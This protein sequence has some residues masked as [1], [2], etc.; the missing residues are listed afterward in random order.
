AVNH[1]PVAANDSGTMAEDGGTLTLAVLAN[2]SDADGDALTIASVTQAA[3][4]SVA[5][6]GNGTASY[7][8]FA[9]FNGSDTFAYTVVDG[10]GGLSTAVVSVTVTAVNDAPVAA[11][12]AYTINED[13]ALTVAAPGVL[14]N[15]SDVDGDTPT[16][17]GFTQAAHGAVTLTSAGALTYTPAANYNGSD[18][19]NYT[20]S[21]GHGSSATGAVT[22]TVNAVND[23]PVAFSESYTIPKDTLVPVAFQASDA[24]GDALTDRLVAAPANGSVNFNLDGTLTFLPSSGFVGTA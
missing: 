15:D 11:A 13:T 16:V 5:I 9:N 18:S 7:T 10:H 23:A 22:I 21:D 6:T 24:D 20:V 4:G 8:P 3:H 14:A 2:D 12:D 1:D 19:F 17:A